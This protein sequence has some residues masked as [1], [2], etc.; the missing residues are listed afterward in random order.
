MVDEEAR[1]DENGVD[2]ER[3]E[4]RASGRPPEEADSDDPEGQ[5][6]AILEDSEGRVSRSGSDRP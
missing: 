6:R 5:A 3:I 4:T 2:R 1:A